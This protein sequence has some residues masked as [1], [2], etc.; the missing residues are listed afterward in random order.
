MI[1]K[2][3]TS[4]KNQSVSSAF[5]AHSSRNRGHLAVDLCPAPL[6]ASAFVNS[7]GTINNIIAQ[8]LA[9]RSLKRSGPSVCLSV[10]LL[11]YRLLFPNAVG[12]SRFFPNAVWCSSR[13]RTSRIVS[14][15]I[16]RLDLA[17]VPGK[18]T[19]LAQNSPQDNA[20]YR[21]PY[22]QVF[23]R[24]NAFCFV[25]QKCITRSLLIAYIIRAY[26]C[27]ENIQFDLFLSI[28]TP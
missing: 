7:H 19:T 26:W 9:P 27:P 15:T 5:S 24:H 13:A 18:V 21:Y 11:V 25:L 23:R 2:A 1:Y 16:I 20:F 3:P 10:H 12:S 8:W 17:C 28:W 14:D 4:I 22:G 6:I